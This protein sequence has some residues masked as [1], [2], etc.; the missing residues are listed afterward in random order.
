[1]YMIRLYNSHLGLRVGN[2][3][4][5]ASINL[6]GESVTGKEVHYWSMNEVIDLDKCSAKERSE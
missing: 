5:D 3:L 2:G 4:G 6:K 1:M